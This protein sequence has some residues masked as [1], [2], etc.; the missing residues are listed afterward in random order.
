L[1]IPTGTGNVTKIIK[2]E[3]QKKGADDYRVI[4]AK[5]TMKYTP[6]FLQAKE[7]MGEPASENRK[8]IFLYKFDPFKSAW[9][10]QTSDVANE[11]DEFKTNSVST[12]LMK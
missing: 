8:G 9:I 10:Q 12:A 11:N 1:A 6:E 4:M 5:Y 7:I 2:N 3:V